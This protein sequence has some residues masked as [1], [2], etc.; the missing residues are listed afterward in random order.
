MISQIQVTPKS[1]ESLLFSDDGQT[2]NH[3]ALPA[4]VMRGSGAEEAADPAAWF[5]ERFMEN[6]WSECWRY[7]VY[8]YH[9]FHSTNHEVLGVSRG[10]ATLLLGGEHG[11]NLDVGVGDVILLP[12]GTGH[13]CVKCS[14][15]FQVVGAYPMGIEPDFVRS[16]EGDLI[17]LRSRIMQ[18]AV[19]DKD[20]VFGPDGTLFGFWI[21]HE[22]GE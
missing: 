4:V 21:R 12:A 18:V 20:P 3:P 22:N 7:G 8:P 13:K 15:D 5:E 19:P 6:D 1:I 11:Q 2:P 14:E 10:T 17:S 16:G 9:H